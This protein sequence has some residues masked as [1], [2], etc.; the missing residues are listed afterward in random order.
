VTLTGSAEPGSEFEGFDGACGGDTCTIDPLEAGE[1]YEV[2]ATFVRVR[3]SL[4][5]L[6]VG[7]TGQGRI[8]SSPAGID[9][10]PTAMSL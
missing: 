10:G 6:T 2:M 8:V 7:V 5:P 4:F 9:C 1:T 3:P